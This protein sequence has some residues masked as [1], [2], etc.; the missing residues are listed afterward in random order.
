[1]MTPIATMHPMMKIVIAPLTIAFLPLRFQIS[2]NEPAATG[3]PK[4]IIIIFQ[5]T[6][7]IFAS[8]PIATNNIPNNREIPAS[9]RKLPSDCGCCSSWASMT[10]TLM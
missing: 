9:I 5:K 6:G 3:K 8:K 2:I 10:F 4:A 7:P 1:M